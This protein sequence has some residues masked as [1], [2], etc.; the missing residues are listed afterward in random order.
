MIVTL[1]VNEWNGVESPQATID[2]WEVKKI[3]E[4]RFNF[5]AL[6]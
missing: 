5:D 6:F 2:T 1:S 4:D 3:E